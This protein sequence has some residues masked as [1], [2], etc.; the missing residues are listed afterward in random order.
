MSIPLAS[1]QGLPITHTL[2]HTVG[3]H[4][5]VHGQPGDLEDS[6]YWHGD[7]HADDPHLVASYQN[8]DENYQGVEIDALGHD[9][10]LYDDVVDELNNQEYDDHPADESPLST[11]GQSDERSRDNPERR[12]EVGDH[13]RQAGEDPHG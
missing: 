3:S 6:G 13:I 1:A 5:L 8:N 4:A 11:G 2:T 7:Q 9:Q 12:T 10:G